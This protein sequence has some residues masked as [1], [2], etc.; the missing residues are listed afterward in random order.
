MSLADGM[1]PVPL[2]E[3]LDVL[4]YAL[5]SII[6]ALFSTFKRLRMVNLLPLDYAE[7]YS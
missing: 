2:S 7:T 3:D 4:G 5:I 6:T 1:S